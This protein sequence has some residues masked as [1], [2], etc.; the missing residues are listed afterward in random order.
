MNLLE[1]KK[2]D[3]TV[4]DVNTK[5]KALVNTGIERYSNCG[6]NDGTNID[7]CIT[8]REFKINYLKNEKDRIYIK[9]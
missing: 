6:V 4:V 2:T 8:D 7:K 9:I 1:K 5:K 3:T